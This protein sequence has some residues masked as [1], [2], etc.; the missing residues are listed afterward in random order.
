[1]THHYIIVKPSTDD[2]RAFYGVKFR[3]A[4]IFAGRSGHLRLDVWDNTN[5]PH[6]EHCANHWAHKDNPP[7]YLNPMNEGTD[8]MLTFSVSPQ[9]VVISNPPTR[10]N[11]APSGEIRDGDTADVVAATPLPNGQ[12]HY[13]FIAKL[14]IK[15]D[16]NNRGYGHGKVIG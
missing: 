6:N 3:G 16:R 9:S 4:Q 13:T 5:R 1:M 11:V 8:D 10:V 14:A 7:K 2:D 12:T 15:M